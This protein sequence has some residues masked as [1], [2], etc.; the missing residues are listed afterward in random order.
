MEDDSAGEELS[1]ATVDH[2]AVGRVAR[3]VQIRDVRLIQATSWL[4]PQ[5]VI[6]EALPADWSEHVVLGSHAVYV[7]RD[8]DDDPKRF[9]VMTLFFAHFDHEWSDLP[10]KEVLSPPDDRH[11]DIEIEARYLL[12]YE[13]S[14]PDAVNERDL[15][16]FGFFNGAWNAWPYWREY[17]QSTSARMGLTPA[18]VVPVFRV[19]KSPDGDS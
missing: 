15:E 19:P 11:P 1:F 7:E 9:F 3:Y 5:Y 13:L 8:D 10:A 16:H 18:L 6:E 17:A 14:D 2:D 12:E 4:G